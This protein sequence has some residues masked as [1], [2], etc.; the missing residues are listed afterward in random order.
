[1]RI[2]LYVFFA[3]ST[4]VAYLQMYCLQKYIFFSEKQA[5]KQIFDEIF[6]FCARKNKTDDNH[7]RFYSLSVSKLFAYNIERNFNRNFFVKL[8]SCSE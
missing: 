4:L 6:S 1:M 3:N 8:Q 7:H 5:K 2:N